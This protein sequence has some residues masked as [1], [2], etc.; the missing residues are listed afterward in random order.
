[1]M[2][3]PISTYNGIA[4]KGIASLRN[5]YPGTGLSIKPRCQASKTEIVKEFIRGLGMNPDG[6]G[7]QIEKDGSPLF[8]G[9]HALF[10]DRI[11]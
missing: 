6:G 4:S 11:I 1:M 8:R 2:G 9:L 7:Y 10:I 5:I 3:H